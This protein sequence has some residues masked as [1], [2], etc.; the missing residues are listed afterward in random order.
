MVVVRGCAVCIDD[1]DRKEGQEMLKVNW[2][3]KDGADEYK[4]GD[5]QKCGLGSTGGG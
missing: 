1:D 2:Y 4:W 3:I 5:L